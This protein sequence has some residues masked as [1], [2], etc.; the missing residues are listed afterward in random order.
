MTARTSRTSSGSRALVASSNSITCGSMARARAMATRCCWPPESCEGMKSRRSASP[1][2]VSC[3]IA[4][5]SASSRLRFRT[6]C[7]AIITFL[8]TERCG[9][10]LN[11]WNT[12]PR[13]ERTALRS[14][15]F[16]QMLVPSKMIWPL[17]GVS[18]RFTQRSIV[19]LPEPEGPSTTTTSPRCTSRSIPRRT[20]VSPKDLCRSRML[21]MGSA[22]AAGAA[23]APR[24][25]SPVCMGPPYIPESCACGV[26]AAW[27]LPLRCSPDRRASSMPTTRASGSVTMR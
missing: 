15:P 7:C 4:T 1:T 9:K 21:T 26:T 3:S 20:C 24:F 8:F 13:R 10:R 6:F 14:T 18:S 5:R 25:F 11:C 22:P 2:R 23:C 17:V 19:D 16:S 27:A 12:M